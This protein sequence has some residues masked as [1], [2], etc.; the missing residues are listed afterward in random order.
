ML[1]NVFEITELAALASRKARSED[2]KTVRNPLVDEEVTK[3][4]A[5]VT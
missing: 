2:L 5:L 4:W 1:T 3:G